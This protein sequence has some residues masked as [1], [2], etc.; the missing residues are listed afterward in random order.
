MLVQLRVRLY[1]HLQSLPLSYFHDNKHGNTL[2]LLTNDCTIISSFISSTAVSVLPHLLV[3]AGSLSCICIINPV[4]ALLTGLLIPLFYLTIK[5]L[6]RNIRPISNKLLTQ[7]AA[8]FALAEENLA[9]LP[10][11]KS[12]TREQ[13]ESN[14]FEVSNHRL[15]D[16]SISYLRA[17][18]RLAPVVRFLFFIIILI[19]LWVI[20][21][22]IAAGKLSAGQVVSMM[23]YGMLLTQPVSSLANTY[24][25]IQRAVSAGER[26]LAVFNTQNESYSDG[27]ALPE[28][29]S[30]IVFEHITFSYP[31]REPILR[32]LNLT[33]SAGETVA[34][35]GENGAGKS[36][37]AHLLMRFALPLHGVITIDGVDIQTVSLDS[38]RSHIGLVQQHV[39]LQ[40][41]SVADNI[42]FGKADAT[43]E[44]ITAAAQ[45]AHALEFIENLPQ[46]F[47]TLIGD[48]G[49]KLS[50]GQ[51]QRL[52]LARALLKN[53]A[54]LILDEATAMFDPEGEKAFI[55][56]NKELLHCRTVILI[57]H[58]PASL[59]LADRILR[60]EHGSLVACT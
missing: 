50:G 42:L 32:D 29:Q 52:S 12:F 43:K 13:L 57:T 49:I 35:T 54:I 41:S 24:G 16:L 47:E 56:Q 9:T 28:I 4:V 10:I 46:G 39:L 26:L 55:V 36:T 45:A 5:L 44:E 6:G 53:P 20:G 25:S 19:I 40:N 51:K 11:I 48:Q 33:V 37:L 23:F 7:Y 34:I 30:R 21:D 18:A 22:D 14:R 38:L 60:L 2:A 31:G 17:H 3:V 27:I 1:D 8:T 59:A 58:R 15:Y